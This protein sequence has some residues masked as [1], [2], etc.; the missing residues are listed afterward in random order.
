MSKYKA[1]KRLEHM[2]ARYE[3]VLRPESAVE[4]RHGTGYVITNYEAVSVAYPVSGDNLVL[5]K[6]QQPRWPREPR[7]KKSK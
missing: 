7:N 5:M 2:G 4:L 3:Y 1:P 6:A